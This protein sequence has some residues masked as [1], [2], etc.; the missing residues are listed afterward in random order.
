M[1]RCS[2]LGIK[3]EHKR[4]CLDHSLRI[5]A[6]SESLHAETSLNMESRTIF[7]LGANESE[8]IHGLIDLFTLYL[9]VLRGMKEF[10]LYA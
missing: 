8:R 1:V 7:T 2:V 3:A 10:L 4:A 6:Q 5:Y 9:P